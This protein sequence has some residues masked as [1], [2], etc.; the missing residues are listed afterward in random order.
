M[1]QV[2]LLHFVVF[3][4]CSI[5]VVHRGK[6]KSGGRQWKSSRAGKQNFFFIF[7]PDFNIEISHKNAIRH[8]LSSHFDSVEEIICWFS[9]FYIEYRKITRF[10]G[11][12]NQIFF[13][14]T[15]A[16][17]DELG[18][19]KRKNDVNLDE[20]FSFEEFSQALKQNKHL[21]QFIF[22]IKYNW[23]LFQT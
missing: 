22:D 8:C 6:R 10:N 19:M 23:F 11:K 15:D 14:N 18:I 12:N 1:W 16:F 21:K 20:K 7:Q 4:P 3:F 9:K 13:S 5:T 17:R 2:I